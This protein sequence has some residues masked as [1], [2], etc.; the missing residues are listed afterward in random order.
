MI[1][2][3]VMNFLVAII[4]GF[5]GWRIGSHQ[6]R[7]FDNKRCENCRYDEGQNLD[8]EKSGC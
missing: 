2:T 8:N 6:Q 3:N 5:V 4:G 1:D 7:K